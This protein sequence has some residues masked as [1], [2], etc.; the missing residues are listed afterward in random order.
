MA[1]DEADD[2]VQVEESTHD[3]HAHHEVVPN[4]DYDGPGQHCLPPPVE[5]GIHWGVYFVILVVAF[6]IFS[7][8]LGGIL[9]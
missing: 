1:H 8:W 9:L 7:A 4:P 6:L 2:N 5:E 3:D